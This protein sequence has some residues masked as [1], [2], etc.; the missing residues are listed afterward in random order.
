MS[1]PAAAGCEE[2]RSSAPGQSASATIADLNSSEQ[3][4]SSRAR[5]S[6]PSHATSGAGGSAAPLATPSAS[7]AAAAAGVST[8]SG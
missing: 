5:A 4:A 7:T 2:A 3:N 1:S 8:C 6:A